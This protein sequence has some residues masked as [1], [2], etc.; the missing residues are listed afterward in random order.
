[1]ERVGWGGQLP[2]RQEWSRVIATVQSDT[3]FSLSHQTL[4][5]QGL[6]RF[7]AQNNALS[8]LFSWLIPLDISFFA[9][10]LSV[11]FFFFLSRGS[12]SVT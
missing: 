5:P 12:C 4:Q 6:C 8:W 2:L 11:L 10:L 9:S 3:V 1:M 7:P